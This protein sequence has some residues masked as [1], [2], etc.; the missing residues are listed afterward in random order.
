[1][2]YHRKHIPRLMRRLGVVL[3]FPERRA[4]E[5]D[6]REVKRWKRLRLP[7]ILEYA[8]KRRGLVFHADEALVSLIPYVGK[9]WSF[10]ECQPIVKVSGKREQHIGISAAVNRQGRI[11]FEL[12]KEHE[13]FTA[14][15]FIRFVKKIRK[16]FPNRHITLIADG[17]PTHKAK[18]VKK[19]EAENLWLRL[20]FYLHI[21]Q[22]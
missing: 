21:L 19:F 10:P 12:T 7:E 2:R 11:C 8:K 6:D 16:E 3:K 13:R 17:A 4:L 5:Q 18:I 22:S 9:T 1:M 15:T 20:K 14:K